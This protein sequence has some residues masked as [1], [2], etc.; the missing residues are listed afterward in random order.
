MYDI[1]INTC[2]LKFVFANSCNLAVIHPRGKQEHD[3]CT[4]LIGDFMV[5]L[6]VFWE[7]SEIALLQNGHFSSPM[8]S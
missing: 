2:D 8:P 5:F 1:T 3:V 6:V 7:T 4:F